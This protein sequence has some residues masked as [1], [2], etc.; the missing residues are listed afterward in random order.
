MTE[1]TFSRRPGRRKF[2]PSSF[3]PSGGQD[4]SGAGNRTWIWAPPS[5]DGDWETFYTDGLMGLPGEETGDLSVPENLQRFRE[6]GKW[7][8]SAGRLRCFLDQVQPGDTIYVRQGPREIT[9]RGIVSGDYR[10]LPAQD[11]APHTRNVT[12]THRGHWP[13]TAPSP[14]PPQSLASADHRRAAFG[15]LETRMGIVSLTFPDSPVQ[16][17]PF[18][19]TEALRD[20]FLPGGRFEELLEIWQRK[21]NLILQGPPGV[22]KTHI[23]QRLAYALLGRKDP[24]RLE[25]VQFH[26]AYDYAYFVEGYQPTEAGGFSLQPGIFRTFCARAASHPNQPHVFIIDEINRGN[27]AAIFGELLSLIEAGH[28]G[29]KHALPLAVS[30]TPFHIP[31]NVHLLGLMNTADRS[32]IGLDRALRRRF[33]FATLAPAFSHPEFA[34]FLQKRQ[35][36]LSLISHI[37]SCIAEL[38]AEICRAPLLGEGAQ[39]GHSFFIPESEVEDPDEWYRHIVI[40]ELLPLLETYWPGEPEHLATLRQQLL[41][42]PSSPAAESIHLHDDTGP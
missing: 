17:A 21:K 22:G 32:L 26:Q 42:M 1:N 36:P 37:R 5:E 39:I 8:A 10:F 29:R 25:Q 40:H 2:R 4:E 38:N 18:T 15:E 3:T 33:A 31:E 28:R 34:S 11:D 14:L 19:L 13:W 20:L 6:E 23:A 30:H 12:W 24:Q 41:N 16:P 9:G 35:I 27:V 7:A